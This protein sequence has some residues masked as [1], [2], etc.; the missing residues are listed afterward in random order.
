M[1]ISN[2]VEVRSAIHMDCTHMV[3]L[4]MRSCLHK[5][6]TIRFVDDRFVK[7]NMDYAGFLLNPDTGRPGSV[8]LP[9]EIKRPW[10]LDVQGWKTLPEL[11]NG[12]EEDSSKVRNAIS[13]LFM[14]MVMSKT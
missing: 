2:E 7:G 1:E 12:G 10:D 13:Q 5:P 9:I 3:E 8:V 6:Y 11:I 4:A 14:C